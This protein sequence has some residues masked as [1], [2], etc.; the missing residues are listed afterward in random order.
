PPPP[1]AG[2]GG[3]TF[4]DTGGAAP[5]P[6]VP[7]DA[8]PTPQRLDVRLGASGPAETAAV[9]AAAAAWGAASGTEVVVTAGA[10]GARPAD[11]VTV[12]SD[13]LA[14]AVAAGSLTAYAQDLPNADDFQPHL[15]AAFTLDGTFWCAPK[16]FSTL[17]LVVD[18]AA[19][20]AAGLTDADVPTTWEALATVA[21]RLTTEGR[22]GL[23]TS[24]E[25][26]R[27]GAFV[28]QA[29]GSLVDADGRA[30]ADSAEDLQALTYVQSLLAAGS[31]RF[32]A[33]VGARDGAEALATGRAAMTVE[34]LGAVQALATSSP[35]LAVRVLELPAG[36]GGRGTLSFTSCW[37]IS[38]DSPERDR[39][40]ALVAALTAT[41]QQLLFSEAT[42][43][44][45]S[46]TSAADGFRERFPER[47]AFLAGADRAT[48]LPNLPGV[49]GVVD[50]LD[51]QLAGL[52]TAD[53]AAVLARTQ[54][55]LD[56][57]L[58]G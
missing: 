27:L 19:W 32:A 41:D 9:A 20:T 56:A 29:G 16:D 23:V 40:K 53:A 5:A 14:A 17:A 11:V 10:D 3:S 51:A 6:G 57:A 46:V 15:R 49:A 52:A 33:D 22:T 8:S 34:S 7:P 25:Y 13:D 26:R 38:A 44:V 12:R 24:S 21:G 31:M 1:L 48:T 36:P 28:A 42:G 55:E 39:A 2:C 45:P 35:G 43:A 58:D 37:G 47:A 54:A 4:D 50:R 30:D 18:Q